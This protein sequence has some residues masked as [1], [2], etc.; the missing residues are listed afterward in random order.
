VAESI[1]RYGRASVDSLALGLDDPQGDG[2][3]IATG[4]KLAA[5]ALT[6]VSPARPQAASPARSGSG[7]GGAFRA[8]TSYRAR[9]AKS[10]LSATAR[11]MHARSA[12]TGRYVKKTEA[13]AS[14]KTTVVESTKAKRSGRDSVDKRTK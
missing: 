3:V 2:R 5:L 10:R 6:E 14:P 7:L 1:R 12:I 9:T 13:K 4:S 8:S 11:R